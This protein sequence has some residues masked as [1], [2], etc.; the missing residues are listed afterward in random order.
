MAAVDGDGYRLTGSKAIVP[1]GTRADLF[2]VP[3]ETPAGVGV[4]LVE[5]GDDGVTLTAQRFSDGDAVARLDL[6]GVRVGPERV[7]GDG[8]RHG[9]GPA[10]A[11]APARRL[12]ASSSASPRERSS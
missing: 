3:A 2:L 10:P 1:A 5:P 8:R 12:R 7:L 4:F 11:A 9:G 6:D